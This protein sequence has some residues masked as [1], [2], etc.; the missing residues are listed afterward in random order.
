MQTKTDRELEDKR[1]QLA[2]QATRPQRMS[3][4]PANKFAA[5]IIQVFVQDVLSILEYKE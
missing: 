4:T 5:D 2:K 3:T 1:D